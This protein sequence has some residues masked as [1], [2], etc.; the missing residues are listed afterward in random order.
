MKKLLFKDGDTN[1]FLSTNAF[2]YYVFNDNLGKEKKRCLVN[3]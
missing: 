1:P 3:L 2:F